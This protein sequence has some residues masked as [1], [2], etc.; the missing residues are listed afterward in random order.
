LKGL[1]NMI[2]RRRN[3]LRRYDEQQ[4]PP[5][6]TVAPVN[7]LTGN[8]PDRKLRPQYRVRSAESE[9]GNSRYHPEIF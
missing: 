3:A 2:Q 9:V 4:F 5:A 7:C 6:I 1:A 8:D